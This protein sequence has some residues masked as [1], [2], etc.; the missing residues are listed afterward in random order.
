MKRWRE[1]YGFL[2]RREY[3]IRIP[4]SRIRTQPN[5][6]GSA[7]ITRRGHNINFLIYH[8]PLAIQGKHQ[9]RHCVESRQNTRKA[10][11][12]SL[13]V[14]FRHPA[15]INAFY[16]RVLSMKFSCLRNA[17][18]LS[19]DDCNVVKRWW[20]SSKEKI[21]QKGFTL[22]NFWPPADVD[23]RSKKLSNRSGNRDLGNILET[24]D[25]IWSW[26]SVDARSKDEA[27][28]FRL[29]VRRAGS[30]NTT[31]D[32]VTS[33]QV[34]ELGSHTVAVTQCL[35]VAQE[36]YCIVKQVRHKLQYNGSI[37]LEMSEKLEVSN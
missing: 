28:P 5:T 36:P 15:R 20:Q 35:Q 27:G 9:G 1:K 37:E 22:D 7:Y 16:S 34:D 19:K 12:V 25:E 18:Q 3:G 6:S 26:Q 24:V 4:Y 14:L 21:F 8:C 30:N 29:T 10:T 31:G 13:V 23:N 32:K 2:F 17:D 33:F 11:A